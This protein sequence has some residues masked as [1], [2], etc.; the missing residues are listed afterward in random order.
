MAALQLT[1]QKAVRGYHVYKEVMVPTVDKEFDCW[2]EADNR[3]DRYAVAVYKDTQSSLPRQIL[4]VSSCSWST[5]V[6][7][8][9][10]D[11]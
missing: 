4:R 8:H 3:E 11:H 1:V 9:E 5:T 2:Q 6:L 7:C 10:S